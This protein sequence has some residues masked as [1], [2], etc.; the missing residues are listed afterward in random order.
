VPG[1]IAVTTYQVVIGFVAAEPIEAFMPARL[2]KIS[3]S[4]A[5]ESGVDPSAVT[6]VAYAASTR[7]EITIVSSTLSASAAIEKSLSTS[8]FA[9]ANAASEF[10]GL[11][12][13]SAPTITVET[14]TRLVAPE[15][16]A[17]LS[18]P[19]DGS[20]SMLIL[21]V[22][23]VGGGGLGLFAIG[24]YCFFRYRSPARGRAQIGFGTASTGSSSPRGP[25][26]EMEDFR[27]RKGDKPSAASEGTI[28]ID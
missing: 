9:D 13:T 8:I 17:G 25:Y 23:A 24:C 21:I 18:T 5:A 6:T 7:V 3:T 16:T 2:D 14:V 22:A 15:V 10:F 20:S 1:A 28:D 26:T 27:V 11:Q 12:V 4:V 19:T